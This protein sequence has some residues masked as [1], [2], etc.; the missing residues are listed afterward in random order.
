MSQYI[1]HATSAGRRAGGVSTNKS[2]FVDTLS[3]NK[4]Y[5]ILNEESHLYIYDDFLHGSL[6][7][8][9]EILH[10]LRKNMEKHLNFSQAQDINFRANS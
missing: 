3:T 2:Q 10:I 4:A 1:C 9:N 8:K 7:K 6:T 5:H